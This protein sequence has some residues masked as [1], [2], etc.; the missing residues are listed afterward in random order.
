MAHLQ[1]PTAQVNNDMTVVLPVAAGPT[2]GPSGSGAGTYAAPGCLVRNTTNNG[3]F[4]NSGTLAS[5]YW[6]PIAFD[7]R[8]LFGG[9]TDFRDGIGKAAADTAA[10]VTLAASGLR[11]HGSGIAQTDSGVTA[12]V[13]DQG[14]VASLIASAAD[15]RTAVLS[16]GFGTSPL[17]KPSANG[18]IVV[19]ALV[20]QLSALTL[21]SFFLGFCGSAADALASVL[22]AVTATITPATTIGDDFAALYFDSRLTL[23]T[24]WFA[25]IDKA[26]TSATILVSATGVDTGVVVA[27]A[28]TYQLLRVEVDADGGVRMFIDKVLVRTAAAASLT[29]GTA[30]HPVMILD[31]TSSATKTALVKHFAAW[32]S[33]A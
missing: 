16:F 3:L 7:Q 27:A 19:E 1:V 22:T 6:T 5:P 26:N 18:M 9:Y 30:L 15:T 13:D 33:R 4:I 25:P 2:S 31:S 20:S 10:T 23:N 28:G 24:E 32:G 12:T 8:G 17:F 21:R 11:I 14:A 29:V